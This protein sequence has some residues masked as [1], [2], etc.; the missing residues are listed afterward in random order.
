MTLIDPT[1]WCHQIIKK[2]R[3]PI[4]GATPVVSNYFIP[5][6]TRYCHYTFSPKYKRHPLLSYEGKIWS[7][8]FW[9]QR[10]TR[11]QVSL[12]TYIWCK[13]SSFHTD[14]TNCVIKYTNCTLLP[15]TVVTLLSQC[16]DKFYTTV[17]TLWRA[18]RARFLSL[19]WSKLRLCLANRR[20]GYY[21]DWL[22]IVW[23]RDRKRAHVSIAETT[24]L[25]P[26]LSRECHNNRHMVDSTNRLFHLPYP[27]CTLHT[28]SRTMSCS[29]M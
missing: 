21:C 19:A 10:Q 27:G 11:S 28:A 24:T 7:I 2:N 16:G 22:S 1:A 25:V 3:W 12:F 6:K 20:A 5:D 9:V 4:V 13:L 23:A 14:I 8:L 15:T 29:H 17:I 18:A 26:Y